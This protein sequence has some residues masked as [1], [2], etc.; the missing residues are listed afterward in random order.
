MLNKGWKNVIEIGVKF[1]ES[2]E[3]CRGNVNM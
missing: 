1:Y 2:I 3:N